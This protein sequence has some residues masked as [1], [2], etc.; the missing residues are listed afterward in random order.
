M[1][2]GLPPSFLES[3][4]AEVNNLQ[5]ARQGWSGSDRPGSCSVVIFPSVMGKAPF[6]AFQHYCQEAVAE[7][8]G[9]CSLE[10]TR[11]HSYILPWPEPFLLGLELHCGC[12]QGSGS[13]VNQNGHS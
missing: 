12:S 1:S 5:C 9:C 13:T 11:E 7:R 6:G 4:W 2:S 3:F 10:G 8:E